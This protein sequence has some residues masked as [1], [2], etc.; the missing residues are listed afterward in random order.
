MGIT[1]RLGTIPLAISTDTSN[2]VGIGA[3]PSGTYKLE[4]T[5]T[6]KV[7]SNIIG[8]GNLQLTADGYVYGN[9]T[10]GSGTIRAGIRFDSTNQQ[11]KFFTA[12]FGRMT[13]DSSGNVGIGTSSPAAERKLTVVGGAQFTGGDNTGASFNIV[14]AAA[15]Q[16]GADFNL[17]YATGTGYGPLTFT[18]AGTERMRITSGG[19]VGIGNTGN[20]GIRL[21]INGQTSDS[22]TQAFNVSKA[23]GADLIYVRNDGYLYSVGAWSGSDIRL[24]ENIIDLEN[25][26]QKVLGLKARKFDLIDG[27]KNNYGFIAQELQQIIPDAV[28]VFEEKEQLLAVRMDFIIP[29]LVK[30]IQ[31]LNERLNKAGL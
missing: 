5:G 15:G 12:D 23:N 17:S 6:A 9:S 26:L 8:Q 18:L 27:L 31:E 4:V 1:Q 7:S 10:L 13:I 16:N 22:S 28:S 29:H 20:S 21:Y 30:A 3:A 14:P 11:L 2:N 25:G 24:K 19:N